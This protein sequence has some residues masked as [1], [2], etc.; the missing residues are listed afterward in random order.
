MN[1]LIGQEFFDD[2]EELEQWFADLKQVLGLSEDADKED[3]LEE[4]CRLTEALADYEANSKQVGNAFAA[5][6]F[7]GMGQ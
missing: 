7:M 5:G 6:V 2:L 4:V 1:D 3:V